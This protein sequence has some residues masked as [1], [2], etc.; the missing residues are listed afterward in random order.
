MSKAVTQRSLHQV[1]RCSKG[2]TAIE[3]ALI[4]GTV[5]A[6]LIFSVATVSKHL[7]N[8]LRQTSTEL[9]GMPGTGGGS[10]PSPDDS[11]P[12]PDDSS[13]SNDDDDGGGN[14]GKGKGKKGR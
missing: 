6:V 5:A 14:S 2:V 9:S 1:W 13:P 11:S 12:S 4:A 7:D 3:Y 8:S 10:S